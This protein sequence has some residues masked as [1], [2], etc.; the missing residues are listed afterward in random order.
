M[1]IQMN[2]LFG[3]R[4]IQKTAYSYMCPLPVIWAKNAKLVQSSRVNIEMFEDGSLRITPVP[5]A[6]QNSEGT[7]GS[8]PNTNGEMLA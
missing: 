3:K 8:T 6:C 4:K 7:R 2:I 5:Q 1:M